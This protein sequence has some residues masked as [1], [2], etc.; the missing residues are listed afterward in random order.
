MDVKFVSTEAVRKKA[1]GR[2]QAATSSSTPTSSKTEAQ[3]EHPLHKS[4]LHI[5]TSEDAVQL[6]TK[7]YAQDKNFAL[8]FNCTKGETMDE[9]KYH[10]Y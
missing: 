7:G 9:W 3:T 8:L 1:K 5:Y 2:Q 4:G 6:F 10:T